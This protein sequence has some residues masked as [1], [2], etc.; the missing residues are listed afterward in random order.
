M[1]RIAACIRRGNSRYVRFWSNS[2]ILFLN[3]CW[4][5][6]T[7]SPLWLLRWLEKTFNFLKE[8]GN[9]KSLTYGNDGEPALENVF[10]ETYPIESE[11]CFLSLPGHFYKKWLVYA[12]IKFNPGKKESIFWFN[13]AIFHYLNSITNFSILNK[14]LDLIIVAWKT[15]I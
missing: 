3:L 11:L 14:T 2:F 4:M 8:T 9:M 12:W 1:F 5:M 7:R 10:E 15:T 13:L 6:L